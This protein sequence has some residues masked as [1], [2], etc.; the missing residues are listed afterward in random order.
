M[1]VEV[2]IDKSRRKL[3]VYASAG[4]VFA[5]TGQ[6]A[7][8]LPWTPHTAVGTASYFGRF[9]GLYFCIW[10][11]RYTAMRWRIARLNKKIRENNGGG[12]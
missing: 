12:V 11:I 2:R 8:R 10:L 1:Q 5:V 9:L 7:Y 4:E 6:G 3:R